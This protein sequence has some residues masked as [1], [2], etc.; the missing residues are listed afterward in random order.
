MIRRPPRSTLFPYT[1]LFRSS[2]GVP[3][4]IRIRL[5][6][7]RCSA[8]PG[9]IVGWGPCNR[10]DSSSSAHHAETA[11]PAVARPNRYTSSAAACLTDGTAEESPAIA[12]ARGLD[13]A[14]LGI[15]A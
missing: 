6:V 13:M 10:A 4:A 15:V 9:V 12:A 14:A 1:T 3:L 2:L 11:I 5:K 8:T 7:W